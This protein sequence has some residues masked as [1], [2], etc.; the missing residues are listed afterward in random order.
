MKVKFTKLAA[1]LL[2]G[3]A[4]LASGC[5]DYEV[6]IQ[7]VDKK[8]DALATKTAADLQAQVAALNSTISTLET[9]LRNEHKADIDKLN[10]TISGLKSDLQAAID[11][12]LDKSEF[13]TAK[14]QITDAITA[15]SDR[16]KAIEDANFQAQIDALNE[17]VAQCATKEELQ[18]AVVD[19]TTYINGEIAKLNE[20]VEANTAAIKKINEE[21]IPAINKQITDLQN[22]K[23]D[24]STF[25]QYKSETAET[26]RLL[27][28]SVDNLAAL[29]AGFPDGTTIKEYVDGQ[30]AEII[31]KFDDYVL[32]TT[33][34]EF[35]K[36]AATKEELQEVEAV[37]NGRIDGLKEYVDEQD[38]ALK[39]YVNGEIAKLQSQLD[40]ITNEEGTGRLDV[41]E[42]TAEE[43]T[44]KVD[45]V[46][47]MLQFAEG[48]LQGYIDAAAQKAYDDA[49]AYVDAYMEFLIDQLNEILSDIYNQLDKITAL[50]ERIQSIVYVPDYED[51][52][53]T[54]NMA[55]VS[56]EVEEAVEG[57][58]AGAAESV[59][60]KKVAVIDQPTKITYK[61]T[62]AQYAWYVAMFYDELLEFD[63][64]P[65][66]TRA[67]EAEAEVEYGFDILSVDYDDAT[68]DETGEITFTVMPK[69]IASVQFAANGLKPDYH[70]GFYP[71]IGVY[72]YNPGS[73]W[74]YGAYMGDMNA[75]ELEAAI[76]DIEANYDVYVEAYGKEFVDA[77][78]EMLKAGDGVYTVGV[79]Q[80]GDL[81]NYEA[82]T[83]FAASLRL[84][85]NDINTEFWGMEFPEYNEVASTYSALYPAVTEVNILP[86]PY[87]EETD[88]DGNTKLV[89]V[90]REYQYLPYSSLRTNPVGEKA[91]QDPKGYRVIMDKVV[92]AVEVNGEVVKYEDAAKLG[93][94]LPAVSTVFDE[95]TYDKGTATADLDKTN[96][97]E[98]AKV[99]AEIEMNPEKNAA[100]RKTAIGNVITGHY[101][102][103]TAIGKTPFFGQVEITPALGE[104]DI[105]AEIIWTY[106]FDADIDHNLFY[107]NEQV[108]QGETVYSR[109]A[110]EV[111]VDATDM[112]YLK[113]NLD[114]DIT[115]FSHKEP[116]SY[117]ITYKDEEGKDVDVTETVVID[118]VTITEDGKLLVNISNF[119]WD[120]VYTVVANYELD[121]ATITVTAVITTIDRNREPVVV[122][123]G[124]HVFVV[125]G[126]EFVDGVYVWSSEP[127]HGPI[128]KAF[129]ENE[130][131]NV[132]GAVLEN[133]DFEYDAD[134]EDFNVAELEGKIRMAA[135]DK[136]KETT[137]YPYVDINRTDI[138][139]NTKNLTPAVL[140]GLPFNDGLQRD[141]NDPNLWHGKV[142]TRNI[143]TYIG[144]E[145]EI[146]MIFS[147]KVPD[148]NFLHLSYYT[149][150]TE[151]ENGNFIQKYN[152]KD[153][154]GTVKW[155]TQVN[156]SYFTGDYN[157]QQEPISFRHALKDYDVAYIN[158]AELA[159]NVVDDQDVAIEE[160]DMEE[161]GL[162]AEFIYTDKTQGAKDLPKVD[163]IDP[164]L[165]IY[166]SLWVD[167]TTFYY[168]TNEKKFIP[169]LGTL[170]LTVGDGDGAYAFPV[171]TRFEFPKAAV[172]YP[173][174]VLDYSTYA[175]V[176]WTPF[177]EP[178]AEG[179]TMVLDEN[180]IYRIPLF[181]G[182][183]LKD[184]R[185]NGVSYDVIKDG[186]WVVG[187]VAEYDAEAGT[188]TTGGNGYIKDVPA[189]VAYHINTT[190]TY[191][192][193]ELPVDL[194]KLLTI[195]Y[196][197]DGGESFVTE[198]PTTDS[199]GATADVAAY[200]PYVQ[201]D[202]T[203]EV[204]FRGT[205]TIPVVVALENPWQETINFVYDFIIKG[206]E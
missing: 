188:Y 194:R 3:A 131:I 202:Y 134:Q 181:K 172:K 83:A 160:A 144:E 205:V 24:A 96:F 49:V 91:S 27:Q 105:T 146:Q 129:D 198:L 23:L 88:E 2:A 14:Q 5:T 61:I 47:A 147:Y 68:V 103:E 64:K 89:P 65:L 60:V 165:M 87:R 183:Y 175:M 57:A 86:D 16:V 72:K 45:D 122:N 203:S 114:I 195:V 156:P 21:I 106:E 177:Q 136:T 100:V 133:G 140:A 18:Q 126:E 125:N 162:A 52:K 92:P 77:Y 26:L 43:Y 74:N 130:V 34:E 17:K 15:V 48:D 124:E 170:T 70:V 180:K 6:D 104:V 13:E 201:Y 9:T 173:E 184:N 35:V 10:Q 112:A 19:L 135:S 154:D 30:Y 193:L 150:N 93:L 187:N 123:L 98:T 42:K 51:L 63:V 168:R 38:K 8:V 54:T 37:L 158:L 204:Q 99:Y 137:A 62:P 148:Y 200:V 44:K 55:Y 185:P 46:V 138:V 29:T 176:R 157:A 186:E 159:F 58:A 73:G 115:S 71:Y 192:D 78:L 189:N 179:Y 80:Y 111:T 113:E 97:V 39:T 11:L 121:A 171:A 127:L 28:A 206:V 76:D 199:T 139:A 101:N 85:D 149:F 190:F 107:E 163:Q 108:G 169:S 102:F 66:N 142:V 59:I 116:A 12:K 109:K 197:N 143:T 22:L 84:R 155:W 152:F 117:T 4:L 161:L 56:Q 31:A 178:V 36:I 196:S 32:K 95:F 33:F 69:N 132:K 94:L 81:L 50:A 110:Y 128:F 118:G 120:K 164:D 166:Q 25:E 75:D 53:I 79:W 119:E 90:P 41:L 141:E 167:N 40:K 182:M 67:D 153:N 7:N 151:K 191:D 20:K 174:E 145:V 82:R 1:L